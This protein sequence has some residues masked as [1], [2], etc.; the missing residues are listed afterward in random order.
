MPR[1]AQQYEDNSM[2]L[3]TYVKEMAQMIVFPTCICQGPG[4][5]YGHNIN[6]P[7]CSFSLLPQV[8]SGTKPGNY[9]SLG[10]KCLNTKP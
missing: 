9:L 6:Y 5:N 7:D 10:H 2:S 8:P 3:T 1:N 4:S